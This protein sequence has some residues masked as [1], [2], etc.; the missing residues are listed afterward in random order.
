MELP[1]ANYLYPLA[2]ISVTFVAFSA[3]LLVLRTSAAR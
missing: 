1:G 3:L 2:T